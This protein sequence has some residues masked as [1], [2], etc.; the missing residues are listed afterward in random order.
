MKKQEFE[1]IGKQLLVEMPGFA[2]RGDLLFIQPVRRVLRGVCFD[3]S[4]DPNSFY[5]QFFVQPLFVPTNLAN[6]RCW[7]FR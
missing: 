2:D 4:I 7:I 3:R 6:A 1:K 5:V